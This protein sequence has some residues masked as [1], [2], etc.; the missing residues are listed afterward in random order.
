MLKVTQWVSNTAAEGMKS[1]NLVPCLLQDN[2]LYISFIFCSFFQHMSLEKHPENLLWWGKP[3]QVSCNILWF[4]HLIFVCHVYHCNI[5]TDNWESQ[6]WNI[7][8]QNG[9]SWRNLHLRKTRKQANKKRQ[10]WH[11]TLDKCSDEFRMHI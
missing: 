2:D 3:S 7:Y 10:I 1:Q 6:M 11:W 8:T 5:Y 9:P 4:S